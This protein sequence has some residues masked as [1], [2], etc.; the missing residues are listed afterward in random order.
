MES[1]EVRF[2][3]EVIVFVLGIVVGAGIGAMILIAILMMI[4]GDASQFQSWF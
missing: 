1:N 4:A 3:R 2:Y